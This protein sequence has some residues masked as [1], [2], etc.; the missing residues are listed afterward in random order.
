MICIAVPP[1]RSFLRSA[2][3]RQAVRSR[4]M[5]WFQLVGVGGFDFRADDLRGLDELWHRWSPSW[6]YTAEQRAP[7]AAALT[8]RENAAA[9]LRYYRG[10]ARAALLDGEQRTAAMLPVSVPTL[11]IYGREDGCLGP[12][13]MERART[14]FAGESEFLPVANAG[15][16]AHRESPRLVAERALEWWRRDG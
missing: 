14:D 10:V 9:A 11:L 2:G 16:F 15:H 7:A 13:V 3:L 1:L 12:E 6:A 4:Y 8:N 5:A